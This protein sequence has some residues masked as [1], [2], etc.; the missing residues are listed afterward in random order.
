MVQFSIL[1]KDVHGSKTNFLRVSQLCC[2]M[3]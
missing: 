1:Y 3:A 2:L